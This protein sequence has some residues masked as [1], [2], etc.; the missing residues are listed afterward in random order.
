MSR[1]VSFCGCGGN[2]C[3]DRIRIA[4]SLRRSITTSAG[5]SLTGRSGALLWI[6]GVFAGALDILGPRYFGR[7]F[8]QK[9]LEPRLRFVVALRD[10]GRERLGDIAGRRIAPGDTRQ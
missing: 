3:G 6:D 8:F 1:S 10:R 5:P 2:G 4:P 7:A 9:R